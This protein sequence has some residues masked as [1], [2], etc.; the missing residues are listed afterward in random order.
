MNQN[1]LIAGVDGINEKLNSFADNVSNSSW[2]SK[3]FGRHSPDEVE[4]VFMVGTSETTPSLDSI[5][6]RFPCPWVFFRMLFCLI[7]LYIAF[8]LLYG[9]FDNFKFIPAQFFVGAFAVPISVLCLFFELNILRNVSVYRVARFVFVGGV[10]SLFYSMLMYL[11]HLEESTIFWAG[12][13]EE[14]GKLLAMIVVAE[15]SGKLKSSSILGVLGLPFD[16]LIGKGVAS[17]KQYKWILN[18]LLFGAS[19][20]VGF[21]VFETMGYAF[22]AFFAVLSVG[23]S[24]NDAVSIMQ[25]NIFNRGVLSPFC[26]VV[27]SAICGGALWSVRNDGEWHWHRL[28][29]LRLLAFVVVASF[30]HGLWDVAC[31]DP[32]AYFWFAG[33]GLM[34]WVIVFM[35]IRSGIK[36]VRMA[37][38]EILV[39]SEPQ[40]QI[41]CPN[42]GRA[43]AYDP[44]LA[45]VVVRCGS[46]K[47]EFVVEA[48]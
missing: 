3:M 44:K 39:Q 21:A 17:G 16:L 14:F 34:A 13:I 11:F 12:P 46:C 40:S 4:A 31:S 42:C 37:K 43:Y 18:G 47:N 20:G 5:E 10:L 1:E 19:V 9:L 2:M 7:L 23:G 41:C 35:Q 25:Q 8:L 36:Q 26:H 30:L 45:G 38:E 32:N 22:E 48:E 15:G 27:W 28:L 6:A 29:H 33:I 24:F